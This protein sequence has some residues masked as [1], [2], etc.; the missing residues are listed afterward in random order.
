MK[1]KLKLPPPPHAA[2]TPAKFQGE[3]IPPLVK[4]FRTK[5]VSTRRRL[6]LDHRGV[7]LAPDGRR[8]RP[9]PSYDNLRQRSDSRVSNPLRPARRS[10]S[11]LTVVGSPPPLPRPAPRAFTRSAAAFGTREPAG[12]ADAAPAPRPHPSAL[13]DRKAHAHRG[14]S[15]PHPVR[16]RQA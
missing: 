16:R 8:R 1:Y 12:S 10:E 5:R 6:H 14:R 2:V 11:S 13:G 15:E 7:R 3:V 4:R 9:A